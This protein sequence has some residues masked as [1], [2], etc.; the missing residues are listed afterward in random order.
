MTS[1]ASGLGRVERG[2][3]RSRG[4]VFSRGL[5]FR[6]LEQVGAKRTQLPL[7]RFRNRLVIFPEADRPTPDVEKSAKCSIGL[8]S[9]RGLNFAFGHS[10]MEAKSS[11]LDGN[12]KYAKRSGC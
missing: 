3:R 10:H 7:T 4:S 12:V 1:T 8:N 2:Q 6:C 11:D 5:L 9:E